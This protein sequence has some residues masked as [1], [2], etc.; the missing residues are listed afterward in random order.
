MHAEGFVWIP[1]KH[2]DI[3]SGIYLK[4]ME[5]G[6]AYSFAWCS[7]NLLGCATNFHEDKELEVKPIQL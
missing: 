4:D 2:E 6:K 7:F 5:V 3:C 1:R